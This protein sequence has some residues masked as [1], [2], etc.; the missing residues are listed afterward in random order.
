MSQ[1]YEANKPSR[2]GSPTQRQNFVKLNRQSQVGFNS[3]NE[4]LLSV[5]Q[6]VGQSQDY[7]QNLQLD[8]IPED[9]LRSPRGHTIDSWKGGYPVSDRLKQYQLQMFDPNQSYDSSNHYQ[10]AA[11]QPQASQLPRDVHLHPA[12][13]DYTFYLQQARQ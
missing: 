10:M 2:Q 9:S 7:P 3:R 5:R 1:Y 11:S 8:A 12:V 4:N 6:G 13:N